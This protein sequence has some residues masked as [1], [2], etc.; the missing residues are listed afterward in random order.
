M[1]TLLVLLVTIFPFSAIAENNSMNINDTTLIYNGKRY[2]IKDAPENISITVFDA[3]GDNYNRIYDAKYQ[4]GNKQ[5]TWQVNE[6]ISF[7][8]SELLTKRNEKRHSFKPHWAGLGLGFCNIMNDEF[9]FINENGLSL[10]FARSF[11]ITW[12]IVTFHSQIRNTGWG[13]VSG[14]G[15]DWRN[16][17][18]D[19]EFYFVKYN[20]Q[21]LISPVLPDV[22]LDYS[23]LKTVH[24]NVPLLAEW[25]SLCLKGRPF[26][27]FGPVIGIK[28]YSSLKTMTR[29]E[30]RKIKEF[31]KNIY[32]NPINVDFLLQLG[33][34]H[35]GFYAKYSFFN[36]IQ[37]NYGPSMNSFSTGFMLYF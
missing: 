5:E 26:V 33:Y 21:I 28:T 12:N 10:N 22:S 35:L 29:Y 15:L 23:R 13:L 8:F 9:R 25:Q 30:N 1:K 20:K 4:N 24:L 19:N 32:P 11:E 27:S 36:M 18:M 37:K 17:V 2:I 6:I 16:Y 34:S 31:S 3:E 7:P 14:I